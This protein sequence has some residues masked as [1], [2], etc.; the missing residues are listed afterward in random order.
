MTGARQLVHIPLRENGPASMSCR[1]CV[2]ASLGAAAPGPHTLCHLEH[3]IFFSF[4]MCTGW[5]VG[6]ML[7][8]WVLGGFQVKYREVC[9]THACLIVMGR[10]VV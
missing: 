2:V 8:F 5:H 7:G 3:V 10:G 4:I 9:R 6:C 1:P